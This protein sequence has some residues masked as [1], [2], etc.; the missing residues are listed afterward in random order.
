MLLGD[1][2]ILRAL[3]I[4]YFP[5][6]MGVGFLHNIPACRV[7]SQGRQDGSILVRAWD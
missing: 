4:D 3:T 1:H 7:P 6:Q 5:I 2:T